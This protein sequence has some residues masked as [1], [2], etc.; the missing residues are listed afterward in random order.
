[1]I[2]DAKAAKPDSSLRTVPLHSLLNPRAQGQ[3]QSAQI[4]L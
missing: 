4:Q 2:A 1:M 3:A